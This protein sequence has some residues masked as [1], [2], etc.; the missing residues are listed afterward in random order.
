MA[1]SICLFHRFSVQCDMTY[2][3]GSCIAAT[4]MD[5]GNDRV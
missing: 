3:V 1:F 5:I 2:H 4:M